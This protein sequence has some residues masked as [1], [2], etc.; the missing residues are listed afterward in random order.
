MLL[1]HFFSRIGDKDMGDP[2]EL[3]S[4]RTSLITTDAV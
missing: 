2:K 4:D 1:F 3:A